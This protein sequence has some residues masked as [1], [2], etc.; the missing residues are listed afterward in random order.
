MNIC[1]TV[2]LYKNLVYKNKVKNLYWHWLCNWFLGYESQ[3]RTQLFSIKL[4]DPIIIQLPASSCN[5]LL[6]NNMILKKFGITFSV[7]DNNTVMIRAVPE[8]LRK[9]KY[10][11]DELKLKLKVQNLLNELVQNFSSYDSNYATNI[12]PFTIHNAIAMEACH[13][14][15]FLSFSFIIL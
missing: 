1:F 10:Y 5:L 9:N 8:C 4:K 11:H 2:K 12:L 14:M 3:I 15:F 7:I 6:S 13:G